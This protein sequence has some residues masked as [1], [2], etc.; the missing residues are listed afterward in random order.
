MVAGEINQ[1][2]G[3]IASSVVLVAS[4][5]ELEPWKSLGLFRRCGQHLVYTREIQVEVTASLHSI[6]WAHD[7]H[8]SA[9]R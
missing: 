5:C 6:S 2:P 4:C 9:Q 1:R 3:K 7:E 8:H